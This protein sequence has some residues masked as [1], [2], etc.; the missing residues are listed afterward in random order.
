MHARKS[1]LRKKFFV[2]SLKVNLD[3]LETENKMLRS[4]MAAVFKGRNPEDILTDWHN[5]KMP[6]LPAEM[7][8]AQ[9][10]GEGGSAEGGSSSNGSGS[11]RGGRGAGSHSSKEGTG[12]NSAMLLAGPGNRPTRILDTADYALVEALSRAQQN[13]VISDP[14][15][16]DNPLIFCSAGFYTLTGYSPEE[17]I[18]RNCRFLQGPLTDPGAVALIRQGVREEVDTA[19]CLINYK[20]D[21]TTFWN[22]FFTAP[23]RGA[24]GRVVNFVGVQCDVTDKVA[25][26]LVAAQQPAIAKLMGSAYIPSSRRGAAA[27]GGAGAAA[28]SAAASVPAGAGAAGGA[29]GAAAGGAGGSTGAAGGRASSSGGGSSRRRSGKQQQQHQQQHPTIMEEEEEDV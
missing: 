23:L 13:F 27:A 6:T 17:V 29:G 11:G 25:K 28:A 8:H 15:L 14:S 7:L 12:G 2:D 5:G 3:K 20:K 18:G 22:S 26:L 19:V 4:F 16:E 9:A 21:G 24:D 1:R 10:G